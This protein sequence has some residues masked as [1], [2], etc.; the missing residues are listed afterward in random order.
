VMPG[1][2]LMQYRTQAVDIRAR[3]CL[4]FTI[5]FRRSIAH[6]AII[7]SVLRLAG[8]EVTRYTKIDQIQIFID[9]THNIRWL[10]IAKDNRRILV[11]QITQYSTERYANLYNLT[12][13]KPSTGNTAQVV[14]KR[15]PL[16]KTHY[17][18]PVSILFK[19]IKYTRQARMVQTSKH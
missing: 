2:Q 18:I 6:R 3:R 13:R 11:M 7:C 10:E 9:S 8:L 15:L 17:Q 16:D 19:V 1:K 4:G 14:S 12:H 5:L